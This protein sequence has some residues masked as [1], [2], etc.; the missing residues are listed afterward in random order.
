VGQLAR[1]FAGAIAVVIVVGGAMV[2]QALAA[3]CN[4]AV[5]VEGLACTPNG[6]TLTYTG[7]G[8]V[9][10]TAQPNAAD[11]DSF[12]VL[13]KASD[14]SQGAELGGLPILFNH[15]APLG[16][17][18]INPAL[19]GFAAG[20]E[21]V[22]ALYVDTDPDGSFNPADPNGA[23]GV[24]GDAEYRVFMGPATRNTPNSIQNTEQG[25][26]ATPP[27][28]VAF[29]VGF[30]DRLANDPLRDN[31]FNDHVFLFEGALRS[32]IPNPAAVWLLGMGLIGIALRSRY[33]TR[34]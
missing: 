32:N 10:I 2:S 16:P 1:W 14:L 12:L 9:R 34:R 27:F 28:N 30:E 4:V 31:D 6:G 18:T 19:L 5:V 13:Y 15:G 8:D 26:T 24:I 23:N 11:F 20:D 17:V 25:G 21:L 3:P 22:F 7:V 33:R 29:L